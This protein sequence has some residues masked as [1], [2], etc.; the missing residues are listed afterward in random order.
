MSETTAQLDKIKRLV[1]YSESLL[2]DQ[3]EDNVFL[4]LIE[5]ANQEFRLVTGEKDEIPSQ[6][7]FIINDIV[8]KRYNRRGNQGMKSVSV[9]GHSISYESPEDDFKPYFKYLRLEYPAIEDMLTVY[10]G[11]VGFY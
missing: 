7:E 9:E 6:Y 10:P 3:L 8:A 4:D 2:T 5:S 11:E 1:G